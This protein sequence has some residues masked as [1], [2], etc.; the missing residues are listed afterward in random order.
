MGRLGPTG[1]CV[2]GETGV[3][4]CG[5]ERKWDETGDRRRENDKETDF[6]RGSMR[7]FHRVCVF[8]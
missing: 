4:G 8:R 5:T 3:K 6:P 1:L 7:V 2:E